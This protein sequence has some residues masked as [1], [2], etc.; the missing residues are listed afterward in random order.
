[1]H[2]GNHR[3]HGTLVLLVLVGVVRVW[4]EGV[5]NLESSLEEKH[6]TIHLRG[7]TVDLLQRDDT[8]I[9]DICSDEVLDKPHLVPAKHVAMMKESPGIPSDEPARRYCR[10]GPW[11]E[12]P[13]THFASM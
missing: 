10:C 7:I 8:L 3:D 5:E 13:A 6:E 4:S 1:M 11:G 9:G 2:E 12:Q